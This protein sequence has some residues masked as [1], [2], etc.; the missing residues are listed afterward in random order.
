[1]GPNQEDIVEKLL[2]RRECAK[3]LGVS[4]A[5][6]HTWTKLGRAPK[7]LRIGRQIRYRERDVLAW[8]EAREEDTH[9]GR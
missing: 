5:S 2:T 3:L 8:L 4:V 7:R 1:M 6:L 9:E